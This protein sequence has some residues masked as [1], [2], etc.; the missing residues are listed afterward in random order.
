MK[1]K[2]IYILSMSNGIVDQY[3]WNALHHFQS[4]FDTFSSIKRVFRLIIYKK[5]GAVHK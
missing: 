3:V 5:M 2:C 4:A 1:R